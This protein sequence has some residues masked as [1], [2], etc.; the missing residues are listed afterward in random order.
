MPGGTIMI[1]IHGKPNFIIIKYTLKLFV[2]KSDSYMFYIFI[3][4]VDMYII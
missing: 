1:V 4:K 2:C 3:I